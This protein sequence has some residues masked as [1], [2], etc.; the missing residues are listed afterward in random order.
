MFKSLLK[1]AVVGGIIV[2]LWNMVSW[3]AIPWHEPVFK[4]FSSEEYVGSVIKNNAPEKGIYILPMLGYGKDKKEQQQD[5]VSKVKEGPVV[6]AAVTPNGLNPMGV[7]HFFAGLCVQIAAG[8]FV[9]MI[10]HLCCCHNYF[11]RVIIV[12]FTAIFTGI[13]GFVPTLVWWSF[14]FDYIAI[15]FLDIVIGW[16]IAGFVLA[17]IIKP[18]RCCPKKEHDIPPPA[19]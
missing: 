1:G 6:F 11:A 14:P 3:L 12:L 4:G 10:L 8:A 9:G 18:K 13:A 15:S 7:G 17:A 5:Y 2:F 16:L 19:T